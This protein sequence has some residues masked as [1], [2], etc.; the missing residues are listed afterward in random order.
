MALL[1]AHASGCPVVATAVGAMPQVIIDGVTGSIVPPADA[2]ALADAI[3]FS[4]LHP[5]VT[6][7]MASAGAE[8]VRQAY[9]A[10]TMASRYLEVYDEILV[11]AENLV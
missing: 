3:I 7:R 8:R 1:E 4:L 10:E 6:S 11:A 5:D 9:S 2:N